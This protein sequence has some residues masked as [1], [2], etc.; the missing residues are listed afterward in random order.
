MDVDYTHYVFFHGMDMR[1]SFYRTMVTRTC[2]RAECQ[3]LW[4]ALHLANLHPLI[5][6][7]ATHSQ[8]SVHN[9]DLGMHL[10]PCPIFAYIDD[11]FN[12]GKYGAKL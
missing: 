7:G 8:S 6:D 9:Y 5:L 12:I 10:K 4:L 3:N 1:P 2:L 11:S